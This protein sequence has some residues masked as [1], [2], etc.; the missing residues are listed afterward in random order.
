MW[1]PNAE[2][3]KHVQRQTF[4][5]WEKPLI[6][7]SN[8]LRREIDCFYH[9]F[10]LDDSCHPNFERWQIW[11]GRVS[12]LF[13]HAFL[14]SPIK[15]HWPLIKFQ[16]KTNLMPGLRLQIPHPL[17]VAS[18]YNCLLISLRRSK[19][20]HLNRSVEAHTTL[21]SRYT[22]SVFLIFARSSSGAIF[23]LTWKST[24]VIGSSLRSQACLSDSASFLFPNNIRRYEMDHALCM[25]AL[26]KFWSLQN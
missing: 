4:T 16:K 7:W 9:C 21:Y 20:A 23:L 24:L 12:N 10:I 6:S 2:C 15:F 13:S 22:T 3:K 26:H 8:T 18:K 25:V 1:H 5:P 14:S 19:A 17:A 11:M